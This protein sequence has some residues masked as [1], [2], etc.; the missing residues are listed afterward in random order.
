MNIIEY[1]IVVNMIMQQFTD[2]VRQHGTNLEFPAGDS[3][4]ILNPIEK[5]IK[6][7]IE[8]VG[9][10]LKDWDISINYGIK[11]GVMKFLLSTKLN[12]MN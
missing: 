1:N 8:Q 11:P 4:V 10:P 6:E 3:L 5:K 9:K 7:K 12:V 2:Y